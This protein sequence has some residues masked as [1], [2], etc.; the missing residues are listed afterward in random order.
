MN[1]MK[2]L[3]GIKQNQSLA[4]FIIWKSLGTPQTISKVL[5]NHYFFQGG[6]GRGVNVRG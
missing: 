6:G 1:E 2:L 4:S 5:W 3:A